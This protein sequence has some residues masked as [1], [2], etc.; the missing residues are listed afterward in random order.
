M[1][2]SRPRSTL[3]WTVSLV[4]AALALSVAYSRGPIV[5][6]AVLVLASVGVALVGLS[7]YRRETS[8]PLGSVSVPRWQV[9]VAGLLATTLMLATVVLAEVLGLIVGGIAAAVMAIGTVRT[10]TRVE[11]RT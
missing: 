6:W 10:L 7:I 8:A 5:A 1:L 3:L 9:A 2:A 11:D 4:L